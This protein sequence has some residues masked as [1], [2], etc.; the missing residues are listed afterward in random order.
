MLLKAT[1][2]DWELG[3]LK[4]LIIIFSTSENLVS[5]N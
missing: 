3:S 2:I 1:G 4:K 5:R